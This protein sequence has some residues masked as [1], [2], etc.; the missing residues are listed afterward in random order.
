MSTSFDL[1]LNMQSSYFSS[2]NNKGNIL[3]DFTEFREEM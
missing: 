2:D 3:L 1:I